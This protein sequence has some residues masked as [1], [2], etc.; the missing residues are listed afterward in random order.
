MVMYTHP[1]R[2][3]DLVSLK[4]SGSSVTCQT[5]FEMVPLEVDENGKIEHIDDNN[6]YIYV[7]PILVK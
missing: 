7:E 5:Q 6:K 1:N 3:S 4:Q 2:I